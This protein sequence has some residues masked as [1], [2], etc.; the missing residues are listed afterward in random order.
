M[1]IDFNDSPMFF[2]FIVGLIACFMYSQ[3]TGKL[4]FQWILGLY[5][6]STLHYEPRHLP[7]NYRCPIKKG[8]HMGPTYHHPFPSP[9]V[10]LYYGQNPLALCPNTT[11]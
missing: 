8:G 7:L 10:L 3:S 5:L 2:H 4:S 11:S 9:F 1:Q 6:H